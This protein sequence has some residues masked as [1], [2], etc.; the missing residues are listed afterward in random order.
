MTHL[1][2]QGL[3]IYP[4]IAQKRE[5]T[6]ILIFLPFLFL[7]C[8]EETKGKKKRNLFLAYEFSFQDEKC[9]ATMI[10]IIQM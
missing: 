4:I 1:Y 2:V 3:R 5:D 7:T 6:G 8:A 9:R 10:P